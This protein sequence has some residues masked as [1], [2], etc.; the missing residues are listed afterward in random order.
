MRS[1]SEIIEVYQSD[2]ASGKCPGNHIVVFLEE[3][4]ESDIFVLK[5]VS[6]DCSKTNISLLFCFF[7]SRSH[8]NCIWE[9]ENSFDPFNIS[10]YLDI[11]HIF[12]GFGDIQFSQVLK[13]KNINFSSFF[14]FL[15]KIR[16][17]KSKVNLICDIGI[18][19]IVLERLE[20]RLLVFNT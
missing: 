2:M 18:K 9:L 7:I 4:R 10:E 8:K 16:E 6:K 17:L 3:R 5:C 12:K 20:Q 19:I 15:S 1:E 14:N 13:I 11:D